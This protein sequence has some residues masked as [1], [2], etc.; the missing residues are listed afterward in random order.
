MNNPKSA[1]QWIYCES[2]TELGKDNELKIKLIA[3]KNGRSDTNDYTRR[4]KMNKSK[5]IPDKHCK[6][7]TLI[8]MGCL[9]T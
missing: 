6:K 5:Y 9:D 4:S 3:E 2:N 7:A 1:A 8:S